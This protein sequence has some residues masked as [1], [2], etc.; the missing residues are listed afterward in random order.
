MKHFAF[1]L[2]VYIAANIV[3]ALS[4][5]ATWAFWSALVVMVGAPSLGLAWLGLRRR[6][7]T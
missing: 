4:V 1:Q 3:L 2:V 6:L 5:T 7:T